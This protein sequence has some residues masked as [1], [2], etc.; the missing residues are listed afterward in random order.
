MDLLIFSRWPSS[1]RDLF[2]MVRPLSDNPVRVVWRAEAAR[3]PGSVSPPAQGAGR[4]VIIHPGPR[5][6]GASS[7][8]PRGGTGNP[9]SP[10]IGLAPGGVCRASPV[11][12]GTGELLPRRFTLTASRAGSGLL[13][14]A[15]SLGSPPVAVSDHPCP[16]EPGLSSRAVRRQRLPAL[17]Q[18]FSRVYD[19]CRAN[20]RGKWKAAL[21]RETAGMRRVHLSGR[22]G[23]CIIQGYG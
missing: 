21:P 7:D 18:P 16:A 8:L 6:P 2:S 12:R 14:V 5:L 3:K 15:L 4:A 9:Y 11:T 13:S 20:S 1:N 19:S 10:S 23:R 22:D 17:L